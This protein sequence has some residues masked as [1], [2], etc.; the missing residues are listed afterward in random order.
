[1]INFVLC[2]KILDF[3]KIAVISFL[4]FVSFAELSLVFINSKLIST[5]KTT[6]ILF[7]TS[8][9]WFS[10]ILSTIISKE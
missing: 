10:N 3:Y 8:F 2:K 1:M 9:L 4:A 5:F 7:I 6:I